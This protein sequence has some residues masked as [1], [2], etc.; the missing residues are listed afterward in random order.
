[1]YRMQC[2]IAACPWGVPQWNP[3]TGKVVK[4]DYCMDRID[5]GLK[6]A[7]VTGCLTQCLHFGPV[8]VGSNLLRKRYA[9]SL[10]MTGRATGRVTYIL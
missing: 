4:C 7:C 6:P 10:E 8:N 1:M 5:R 2:C 9:E 3:E